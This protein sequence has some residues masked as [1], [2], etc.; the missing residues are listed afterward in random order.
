[1]TIILCTTCRKNYSDCWSC[2]C[3]SIME[4]NVIALSDSTFVWIPSGFTPNGDGLN[5]VFSPVVS[6][7]EGLLDS[8]LLKDWQFEIYTRHKGRL[9]FRNRHTEKMEFR[10]K[11]WNGMDNNGKAM[12]DRIFF[13]RF[14]ATNK[15]GE[16]LHYE[17]EFYKNSLSCIKSRNVLKCRYGDQIVP[18]QGFVLPTAE[19]L[20]KD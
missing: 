16:A 6:N 13:Y 19:Q 12:G 11:G 17:G 8:V 10:I 5:E 15:L 3:N 14:K 1:M 20:C 18:S 4:P 9:I 2:G 7:S